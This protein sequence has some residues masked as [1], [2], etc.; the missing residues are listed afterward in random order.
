MNLSGLKPLT[1]PQYDQ[2]KASALERIRAHIGEQP[3][4]KQFERELGPLWSVLDILAV[5]IFVAALLI[6][7]LH[8]MDY[9]GQAVGEENTLINQVGY[10]FL[11]EASLILFMTLHGLTAKR[12]QRRTWYLRHVSIHLLLAATAAVFIFVANLESGVGILLSLMPPLFTTGISFNLERLIVQSIQRRS[13]VNER[14]MAATTDYEAGSK[15]PESHSRFE[16]YFMQAL[17]DRLISLKANRD[18]S[19]APAAFKVAACRRE[20]QREQWI[21]AAP[22]ENLELPKP[23]KP[24]GEQRYPFGSIHPTPDALES[25]RMNG[26]NG[27]H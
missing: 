1:T 22:D 12:R 6:S 15:D 9:V 19:D 10:I 18:F 26:K 4:R 20:M 8:I 16:Q 13:E 21:N 7:S 25:I 5:V 17:W 3:S 23:D 14:Y 24:E 27:A 2:C 11:A